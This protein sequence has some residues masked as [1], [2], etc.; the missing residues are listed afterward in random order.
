MICDLKRVISEHFDIYFHLW[1]DGGANLVRE[2]KQWLQ[3]EE[4]SWTKM[5]F[6][7]K[8][9]NL[10][11]KAINP[12]KVH[13]SEKLV[14][15]SPTPKFVPHEQLIKAPIRFI[16]FESF[17][18]DL[19][20]LPGS[21]L[22]SELKEDEPQTSC[23][24]VFGTIKRAPRTDYNA[25]IEVPPHSAVKTSLSNRARILQWG[26]CFRCLSEGHY[27]RDCKSKT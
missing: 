20:R 2:E 17:V 10:K 13:F 11:N 21:G 12:K 4:R 19:Q 25:G 16:K 5:N 6:E 8:K 23:K 15:D 18:C 22:F 24:K 26:V 14:Q 7:K 1:R 9:P 27:V 3:E